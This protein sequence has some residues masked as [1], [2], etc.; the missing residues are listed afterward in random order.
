M[1]FAERGA[2]TDEA[3]DAITVA[4]DRR[5]ARAHRP[6]L[7]LQGRRSAA[8]SGAAAAPADLD[9]RVGQARAAPRRGARRRLDPAG[10]A[11]PSSC[12]TTSRTSCAHRDEVRPGAVPEIGFITETV[13][14][15]EPDF[16]IGRYSVSGS[17]Q[18]LVDSFN[19]L[20]AIG[21]SHLQLRFASRSASE[22]CDQVA[23]FGAEV[24]PHLTR[25]LA[26]E[27]TARGAPMPLLTMR[28]D[29]RAPAFGPASTAR[30]LRRR[31]RAD[32]VGRRARLRLPR[33]VGAPRHRRRMD[34][35]AADDGREHARDD[36]AR[37]G[38]AVGVDPAAAR[39]DPHRR[40]DRGDRQR[41]SRPAVDR[42]RRRLPRRRVRD[43]RGRPRGVAARSS[44]SRSRSMLQAWTGE[45]FEWQGR[46]VRVTP[47]PA[48]QPHPTVL[49]GGGVPAAAPRAA[50]L[51]L[52]MM[53][54]NTDPVCTTRTAKRPIAIG[55]E[56]GFVMVP[57]GPTFVHVTDDPDRAWAEIAPYLLYE[58]QTYAS[59][60]TPGQHSTPRVDAENLDDL[61]ARAAALGG[62]AGTRSSPGA[63]ARADGCAELPS[64]SRAACRPTSRGRVSSCSRPTCCPTCA[65]RGEL[66]RRTLVKPG[67]GRYRS[68][69]RPSEEARMARYR[70]FDVTTSAAE[71]STRRASSPCVSA[72]P[73]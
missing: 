59:F 21:V 37:A 38:V 55:F 71:T 73:G 14:V 67:A 30:H 41:V 61:Q 45:P 24:G 19:E 16:D 60:Q 57:E 20:G 3:I 15:G 53:P 8:A 40:A 31:A 70:R 27:L 7:E 64:R 32:A 10:H 46:T 42:A 52:P 34:A 4:L 12:P 9:R 13:Y 26:L 33:A 6:A 11:A 68:G 43:G 35:G 50:R 1:P 17:P 36:R 51:R 23:A 72:A 5:V 18:Q 25:R 65:P 49:V 39:P 29:F 63:G 69:H 28:Q 22:L 48:T 44:R 58:T 47:K 62:Y 66:S 2:I 56:G 54:M